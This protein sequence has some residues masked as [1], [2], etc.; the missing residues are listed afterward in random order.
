MIR[1]KSEIRLDMR[2]LIGERVNMGIKNLIMFVL[3]L[4]WHFP[5]DICQ[6]I[7]ISIPDNQS[8]NDN[9]MSRMLLDFV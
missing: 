9:L 5:R 2:N 6:I 1:M 4:V 7:S 3:Y 8:L